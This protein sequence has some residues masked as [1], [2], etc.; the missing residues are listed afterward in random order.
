MTP[1]LSREVK[2]SLFSFRNVIASKSIAFHDEVISYQRVLIEEHHSM[3]IAFYPDESFIPKLHYLIHY[4]KQITEKG[5]LICSWTMQNEAK[6]SYFKLF[7]DHGIS[8]TSHT[9]KKT[10]K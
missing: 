9:C 1:L 4:A 8:K 5:L 10:P 7:L 6:L 2:T 3:F